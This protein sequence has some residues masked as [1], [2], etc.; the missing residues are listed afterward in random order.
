M[1]A[2]LE[3]VAAALS[4]CSDARLHTQGRF[5]YLIQS[6]AAEVGGGGQ[7]APPGEGERHS[8]LH[9]PHFCSREMCYLLLLFSAQHILSSLAF[10]LAC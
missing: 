4:L 3:P 1:T 7:Q 5:V 6:R 2:V 10:M 9:T 8:S